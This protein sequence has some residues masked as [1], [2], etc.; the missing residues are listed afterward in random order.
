MSDTYLTIPTI[1]VEGD[2]ERT[3]GGQRIEY[4]KTTAKVA[5]EGTMHV[6]R[7][8][9][10]SLRT[11]I[12]GDIITPQVLLYNSFNGECA[13]TLTVGFLR[14]VCTNGMVVGDAGFHTRIIHRRGQTA[15]DKLAAVA[16]GVSQALEYIRYGG[17]AAAMQELTTEVTDAEAIDIITS[18]PQLSGR[19]KS[20]A[21]DRWFL[22]T[23]DADAHHDAWS[24]WNIC[25]EVI[26][27]GSKSR[28][29]QDVRNYQL[30]KDI[31][32]SLDTDLQ[33]VA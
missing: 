31:Q 13:L 26:R 4:S 15:L 20:K 21:I 33:E 22:P 12:N 9:L 11:K 7:Y 3:L 16:A 23:R 18:L 10:H 27:L 1:S 5:G 25:N 2:I 19:M 32:F 14:A 8:T 28:Y 29:R 24:L 17:L 6:T 30:L